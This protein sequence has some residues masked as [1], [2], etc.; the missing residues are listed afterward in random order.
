MSDAFEYTAVDPAGRRV[1]G[2]AGAANAAALSQELQAR[3][4][5]VLH[6]RPQGG[7]IAPSAGRSGR[8]A[9]LETTRALAALLGAGLPL[10]RALKVSMHVA[11][12]EL[13]GALARVLASIERGETL[14]SALGQHP[15]FFPPLYVGIV[16][17]GERSGTLADAFSRLALHL[18]NEEELRARLVSAM[19]YPLILA[20]M[21]G[22]AVAVLLLVVLPRFVE[23]LEGS[24]AGLP[25]STA[26][27]LSASTF[28]KQAWPA[29]L[30]LGVLAAVALVSSR[31]SDRGRRAGARLLLALP[32]VGALRR[33][34]LASRFARLLGILLSGGATLLAALHDT[35]ESLDDPIARDATLRIRDRVREGTSLHQAITAEPIFPGLLPQLV[36]VGEESGQLS[37]VLLKAAD[38]FE[39]AAERVVRRLVTFAEPAMIVFFGGVVAFVALSLLQAIYGINADAFR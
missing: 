29:L 28:L 35:H 9:V 30:A 22:L 34:V 18:E 23:L 21:G 8:R 19:I 4:L 32:G 38:I 7:S 31:R 20:C 13:A 36:A 25:R 3:G 1:R 24:G 14:A 2:S 27:L 33:Q 15:D 10:A 5:I 37:G 26:M 6:I 12:P 11:S 16:R 39:T 17:A